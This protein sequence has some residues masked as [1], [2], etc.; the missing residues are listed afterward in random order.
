MQESCLLVTCGR[1]PLM[2]VRICHTASGLPKGCILG[3]EAAL[4]A[5]SVAVSA[6]SFR[7]LFGFGSSRSADSESSERLLTT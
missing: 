6:G 7:G 4:G 2:L 1:R 3:K 5:A